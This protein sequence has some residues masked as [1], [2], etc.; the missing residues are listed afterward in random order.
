MKEKIRCILLD[1]DTFAI[2]RVKE[3]CHDSQYAEIIASYNCPRKFLN[4][5]YE[6]DFE[7]L[8]LD[9]SMPI[10]DGFKVAYII[11]NKPIIF[12]IGGD[13]QKLKMA[14]QFAPIDLITKPFKKERLNTALEKA[15][16]LLR[17]RDIKK[18][19]ELFN[20]AE[21]HGQVKIL[22]EEILFAEADTSDRRHKHIVLKNGKKYKL[23][24]CI[25][26]KLLNTTSKLLQVNKSQLIS[27]DAFLEIDDD[28]ITLDIPEPNGKLKQVT[29]SRIFRQDFKKRI[30]GV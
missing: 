24:Y 1:N 8:L 27:M 30:T 5:S 25:F 22:P 9:I 11:K 12:L 10:M 4:E 20:V 19:F 16:K 3:T 2:N 28:I 14:T 13:E 15:F 6:I 23:L 26:E 7:L 17:S 18:P 21:T 29:L